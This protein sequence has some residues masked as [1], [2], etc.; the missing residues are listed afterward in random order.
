MMAW[1]IFISFQMGLFWVLVSMLN[2]VGVSIHISSG[3]GY[4][5]LKGVLYV[6]IIYPIVSYQSRVVFFLKPTHGA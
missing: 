5:I 6:H 3:V 1:K 4:W 2:Y